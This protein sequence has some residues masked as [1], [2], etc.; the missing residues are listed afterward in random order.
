MSLS[1]V[2]VV[3]IFDDDLCLDPAFIPTV[4]VLKD[5]RG[6][7][8]VRNSYAYDFYIYGSKDGLISDNQLDI[9]EIWYM[10]DEFNVSQLLARRRYAMYCRRCSSRC[11]TSSGTAPA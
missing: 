9:G 8:I 4:A 7:P 11:A 6:R 1:D 10:I 2:Q 3:S 5:H